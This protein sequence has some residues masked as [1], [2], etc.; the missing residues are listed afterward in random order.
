[1]KKHLLLSLI[2]LGCAGCRAD[3][4]LVTGVI[5]QI[6]VMADGANV[7]ARPVYLLTDQKLPGPAAFSAL[8]GFGSTLT[9]ACCFEVAN[10]TPTS[11]DAELAKYGKDPE[12]SAHMKSIRGYRYIY[13][14]HP[15]ADKGRW[16]PLMKTLARVA[17][18]PNDASP[19]SAGAVVA[20]FDKPML[21]ASFTVKNVTT[22]LQIRTD[23]KTGR[24]VYV[25]T[26][27]GKQ[28][29]FSENAFA[30]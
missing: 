19:F 15:T 16:T 20:Q 7:T 27:G 14:A 26:Q 3:G 11:L 13:A 1:M 30:D 2:A 6:P 25:F 4:L 8:Q 12:F 21:P 9:V 28:V 23:K 10:S 29:E 22:T 18:D 17:S 5:E 24:I